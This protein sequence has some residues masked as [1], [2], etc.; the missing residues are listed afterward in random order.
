MVEEVAG[1]LRLKIQEDAG[2]WNTETLSP[3]VEKRVAEF[4]D[5]MEDEARAFL[6]SA[7]AI[8]VSV[9]LGKVMINIV[10]T[11]LLVVFNMFN[12]A[13]IA[14][15]ALAAIAGGGILNP[16]SFKKEIKKKMAK[17]LGDHVR[18]ER[19]NLAEKIEC[20]IEDELDKLSQ[21][22]DE[23]LGNEINKVKEQV[24][25]V[26][27]EKQES[28]CNVKDQIEMLL[29]LQKEN[30]DIDTFLEEMFT[31]IGLGERRDSG[32]YYLPAYS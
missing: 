10:A 1:H 6:R 2:R 29:S 30:D 32:N 16:L 4:L 28:E 20:Q 21:A 12:P 25:V 17:E 11:I 15:A 23:D 26:L 31:E 7:D 5:S 18:S 27:S 9:A 22:I 13:A 24:E 19:K 14:V 3:M 8:R